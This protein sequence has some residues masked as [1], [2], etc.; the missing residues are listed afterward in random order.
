M[1]KQIFVL[2]FYLIGSGLHTALAQKNS[3]Q[4]KEALAAYEQ[5]HFQEAIQLFEGLLKSQPNNAEVEEKL[6]HSYRK[7]N[8][9]RKAEMWYAKLVQDPYTNPNNKL[10]YAQALAMNG[11]YESSREWYQR[12]AQDA[13][14]DERG[15]DFARV[16]RDTA[17]FHQ[18]A[19][20][21]EISLAPFNSKEA[22][23]SPMYYRGGIVFCSNRPN[24]KSRF[25]LKFNWNN[26]HFLDLYYAKGGVS[27]PELFHEKLNT[28]YHEGPLAFYNGGQSVIFTRNNYHEGKLG[29][30]SDGTHKLKMYLAEIK[31]GEW[32]NIEEFPY[33]DDEYSVG[34]P[35]L[36][37]DG[38]TLY[39]ASDMPGTQGGTDIFMCNLENGYWTSPTNLGEEINT[40]GN[41]M[42]PYIDAD[43]HLYFASDG[44]PGLGGLDIFVSKNTQGRFTLPQNLGVPINSNKDDFGLIYQP[45]K[46][47]GYFS[48]NR[49]GGQGDDDIYYFKTKSCEVL[50][51]VVDS[52]TGLYVEDAQLAVIEKE[53]GRDALYMAENDSLFRFKTAFRTS[54]ILRAEHPDY[55]PGQAYVD[56]KALSECLSFETGLSDTVLIYLQKPLLSASNNPGPSPR[57]TPGPGYRPYPNP[58]PGLYPP[59][60]RFLDTSQVYSIEYIYYDLDKYYIRPDAALT[61][62]NILRVL[63]DYPQMRLLLASHTDSRASYAYNVKLSQRRSYSAYQYLISRGI[64]PNRLVLDHHGETRLVTP[65]PDGV[66]CTEP[67]H[68]L[69]RRTEIIILKE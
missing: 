9:S 38:T 39:F 36:S 61:L 12:Y 56:E 66:P 60:A 14:H 65:C 52:L 28:K 15:L 51:T 33:N 35:T 43:N 1:K 57:S 47:E 59:S 31:D 41:E 11:K 6:A 42:F 46:G 22:D 16:Y 25:K 54:Y 5:Y 62:Q 18:D 2:F 49:A 23:F 69:N 17:H 63:Y 29:E 10:Y 34:H 21:Y 30:S 27:T 8:N 26:T 40:P 19:A 55:A 58:N 24:K 37:V 67:D 13:R 50:F 45:D 68:Q 3:P 64:S 48:S 44:K 53:T 7:I 4:M 20:N 32:S